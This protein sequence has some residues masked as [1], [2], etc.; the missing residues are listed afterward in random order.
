M[1]RGELATLATK[2]HVA[3]LRG[4]VGEMGVEIRGEMGEMAASLRG[5]MSKLQE[6]MTVR[7]GTAIAAALAIVVAVDT[8]L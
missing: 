2:E 8:L 5:E 1:L 6:R 4:D 3:A 7:M